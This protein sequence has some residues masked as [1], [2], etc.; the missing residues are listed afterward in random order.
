MDIKLTLNPINVTEN[1]L[2]K[3]VV[4]PGTPIE[5]PKIDPNLK[6]K[7]RKNVEK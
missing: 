7:T 5:L 4:I 1:I 2:D 6:F 3:P